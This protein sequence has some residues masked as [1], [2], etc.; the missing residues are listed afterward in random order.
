MNVCIVCHPLVV[1]VPPVEEGDIQSLPFVAYEIITTQLQ[2][3]HQVTYQSLAPQPQ[4][5]VLFA[6]LSQ[7][8]L[9]QLIQP[10][11]HNE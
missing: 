3:V 8:L 1:I 9:C 5:P 10:F 4:L 2:P 6:Q 7:A 11:H